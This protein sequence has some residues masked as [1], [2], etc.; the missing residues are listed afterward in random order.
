MYSDG[1]GLKLA[2]GF[3]IQRDL[4]AFC[5]AAIDMVAPRAVTTLGCSRRNRRFDDILAKRRKKALDQYDF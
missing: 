2:F 3:R 1:T 4:T 5:Y